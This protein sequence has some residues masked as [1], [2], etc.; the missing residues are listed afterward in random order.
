MFVV[1][2]LSIIQKELNKF[3]KTWNLR[4]IRQSASAPAGKHD[5]LFEVPSVIGCRKQGV[6]VQEPD[7]GIA[8]DILGI[9]HHPVYKNKEMH[10]FCNGVHMFLGNNSVMKMIEPISRSFSYVLWSWWVSKIDPCES[11]ISAWFNHGGRENL[12]RMSS[13]LPARQNI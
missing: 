8:T 7:I 4:F 10:Q 3:T 1:C 13:F 11:F 5:L 2:F 9:N 6:A 12:L